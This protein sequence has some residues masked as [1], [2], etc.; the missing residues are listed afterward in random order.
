MSDELVTYQ[1]NTRVAAGVNPAN[2]VDTLAQA[3]GTSTAGTFKLT[4]KEP[5]ATDAGE[6]TAAIAYNAAAATVQT[7]LEALDNIK[8]GD[9][10]A[11]GG[12]LPTAVTLTWSDNFAEKDVP[13]IT[14]DNTAN[15]GGTYAVT[16]TTKGKSG[17]LDVQIPSGNANVDGRLASQFRT[18]AAPTISGH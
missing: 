6:Q 10:V 1:Q 11:A 4:V 13:T 18:S 16:E 5:G 9:V 7:A 8:P 15:T 3:T 14:V 12:A 2:E 17:A